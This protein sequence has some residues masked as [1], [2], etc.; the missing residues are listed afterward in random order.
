MSATEAALT[1]FCRPER[2]VVVFVYFML[3]LVVG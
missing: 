3:S 1:S 2:V